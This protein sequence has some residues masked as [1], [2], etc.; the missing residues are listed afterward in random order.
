MRFP[1]I[2]ILKDLKSHYIKEIRNLSALK[3]SE[4]S[5]VRIFILVSDFPFPFKQM[6]DHDGGS[7]VDLK[8]ANNTREVRTL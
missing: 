1:T 3:M 4:V 5:S 8:P 7:N 2:S 6:D